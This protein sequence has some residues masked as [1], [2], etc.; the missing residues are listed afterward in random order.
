VTMAVSVWSV[1]VTTAVV[2]GDDGAREGLLLL[3]AGVVVVGALAWTDSWF[4][5]VL[6]YRV[7]DT[8]RL[9]LHDAIARLAPRGLRRRRVGETAAAAMSDAEQLEWFFAHTV[10]QL[11][12]GAIAAA[13]GTTAA[14][15][16]LGTPGWVVLAGQLVLLLVP[17][18]SAGVADRQGRAL[19]DRIG[20][21]S[22]TTVEQ[23][24]AARELVLLDRVDSAL[25][26]L[27]A[28]TR[29]IQGVRLAIA[30]RV[31]AE[32]AVIE[33]TTAAVILTT[34]L[35]LAARVDAGTFD[36]AAVPAGVVLA[37]VALMPVLLVVTALQKA[38]EVAA[39]A[40]RVE[41]VIGAGAVQAGAARESGTGRT[42]TSQA[43][44][45]R[46]GAVRAGA[47]RAGAV[48]AGAV[49]ADDREPHRADPQ[50]A[51]AAGAV[52]VERVS[53]THD[54]AEHPVLRHLDLRIDPGEHVALVGASGSGKTTLLQA[55]VRLLDIDDGTIRVSGHDIA[56]ETVTRTRSRITLVEQHPHL[57]R[58]S[59]RDNL[60]VAAT[61]ASVGD[62][63]LWE[64]LADVE[65]ADHVRSLPGGLDASLAEHGRTWSGGQR[66]RLG[67]A[68]G[69]LRDP[70]VLLLDEP[71]AHLDHRTEATFL[72]RLRQL[73]AGRTLVI[74]SHRLS[75]IARFD[76]VLFL[77]T[78]Q[79]TADGP[80]GR[81]WSEA[82][83]YRAVVTAAAQSPDPT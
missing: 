5:H 79:V 78:G 10:A 30:R 12:A 1:H 64:V 76:R 71:T 29:A 67:L 82:P 18:C 60:L 28:H 7:I 31:G 54:G 38:G 9:A 65:L 62:E 74:S 63:R 80:A 16:W 45:T 39:S 6:A 32:Q 59:V 47:V 55:L 33:A 69:L 46:A 57:F 41:E 56:A 14:V 21:L 42:G 34:L 17:R 8:I 53:L 66:Q 72:T 73:R 23:R 68:R 24:Q 75:T 81:L 11:A 19:R 13:A 52:A 83:A 50:P 25:A 37:G 3:G 70:D 22:A 48:R 77:D 43:G 27:A 35:T 15:A 40:R 26:D 2:A 58:A 36:P 4:S 51:T 20:A 44:A 49:R 61:D